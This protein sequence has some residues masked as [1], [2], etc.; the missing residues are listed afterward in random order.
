MFAREGS[1]QKHENHH[2]GS[3]TS[4][5]TRLR[6]SA[7]VKLDLHVL[8]LHHNHIHPQPQYSID[9]VCTSIKRN[10]GWTQNINTSNLLITK[11]RISISQNICL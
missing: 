2:P 11:F 10:L 9:D 7:E 4:F 1:E 3:M 6:I 8:L 5:G